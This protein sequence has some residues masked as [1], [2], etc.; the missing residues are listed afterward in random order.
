MSQTPPPKE[1]RRRLAPEVRRDLIV[2]AAEVIALKQGHLPVS[3]DSLGRAAGAS[4]ALI[5]VYFPSQAE[6]FN[7]VLWRHLQALDAAGVDA[8]SSQPRLADAA[9]DCA[10]IYFEHV[11]RAGP[12]IHVILRDH[13]MA[14]RLDAQ[15]RRFIDRIFLRLARAIRSELHLSAK[16]NRALINIVTTVPEEAG[17]LAFTGEMK[18]DRARELCGRLIASSL[19][20]FQSA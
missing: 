10:L 12:I 17:R 8:A 3:L 11:A 15:N 13:F 16:E 5:Y 18:L 20:A 2:D 19:E 9:R 14:P 4:K 1:K 6:L 7:A